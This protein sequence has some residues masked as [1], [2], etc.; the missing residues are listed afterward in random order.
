LAPELDLRSKAQQ[1]YQLADDNKEIAVHADPVQLDSKLTAADAFNVI[2]NS[3][4]R[5][6]SANSD[7]V[8][9]NDAEA[10]HQMR[11]GLR[12]MRAAISLFG[13]ILPAASTER[14][15]AELKWLTSELAPARE[16]DI[17]IKERI[18][19]M[20]RT[21]KPHRGM[22]AIERQFAAKRAT[23]FKQAQRALASSRFRRLLIELL[24]WLETHKLRT[25]GDAKT[26]V[27]E[28]A[29]NFLCRRIRKA[30]K[31][32]RGLGDLSSR[33]RHKLRIK[34]KKIQY[35]IDFFESLFSDKVK[36]DLAGISQRL[37]KIQDALGALND[38][39]AHS[40]MATEAAL[41]APVTNR[42][43][44]AFASGI[45]V[46]QEREAAKT[47]M[48]TAAKELRRLHP[49]VLRRLQ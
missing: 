8:R 5:H 3:T 19:P 9:N 32:G 23:A 18:R 33:E 10:V 6:F 17:F 44:R 24:E 48:K 13:K 39:N 22:A 20:A 14:I 11:V 35:G 46:G 45:V 27:D 29:L 4:L 40:E 38:F 34:I 15:K 42:R 7:A 28:F 36:K 21:T 25:N 2:A 41:N 31:T 26:A 49:K 47:L 43:A 12:R 30:R 1:G 37:K 16:I